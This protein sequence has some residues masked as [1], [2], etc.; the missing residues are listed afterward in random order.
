MYDMTSKY[1][2]IQLYVNGLLE[3]VYTVD[4]RYNDRIGSLIV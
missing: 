1:T 2:F 3:I 4:P